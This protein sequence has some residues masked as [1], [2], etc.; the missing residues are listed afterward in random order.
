MKQDLGT[1]HVRVELEDGRGWIERYNTGARY[2]GGTE[3]YSPLG[4]FRQPPVWESEEHLIGTIVFHFIENNGSC[5]CNK[6]IALAAAYNDETLDDDECG[7]TMA[8][9]KLTLIRPDGSQKLIY[10]EP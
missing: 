3:H 8:I 4:A 2:S 5:D 1:Y 9:A 7:D 10:P 6:K